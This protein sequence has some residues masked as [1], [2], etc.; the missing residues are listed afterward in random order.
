VAEEKR[1]PRGRPK[2]FKLSEE[3][4]KAISKSKTGQRHKQETRDKISRSLIIY[5]RNLNPLSE[6]I[7]SKYCRSDDDEM[8]GWVQGVREELDNLEDV[9]TRKAMLSKRRMEICCGNNIEFF[10]HE[11]TPEILLLFKEFCMLNNL[12][13]DEMFDK[14]T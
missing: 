8:C 13:F 1:R 7:E 11:M 4:K 5:F 9:L 6:D 12:D 2:G 10:S 14:L 3:S